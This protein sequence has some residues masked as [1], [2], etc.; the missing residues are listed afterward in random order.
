MMYHNDR[1][2]EKPFLDHN[3]VL[4]HIVGRLENY[5]YSKSVE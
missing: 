4:T 3:L 1:R 5:E 2:K